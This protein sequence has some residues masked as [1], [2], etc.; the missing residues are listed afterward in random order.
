MRHRTTKNQTLTW[1]WTALAVLIGTVGCSEAQIEEGAEGDGSAEPAGE[2]VVNVY[3]HRHYPADVELMERFTEETGIEV[4][5]VT[6]SA[7]ELITRLENEGE[8]S[9]ADVLITVD[10][11][12][13]HRAKTRDLLQPVDSEVLRENVPE[14]LRDRDGTW[15][16]LTRRARVIVYHRERVDSS[17]LS[18]Y[19][20]LAEPAWDDRVL[21]RSSSNVYNQSLLASL[22]AH[23]GAVAGVAWGAGIVLNMARPPRGGDTDQIKAVVAGAGDV[24]V[25]NTYYVARLATSEDPAEREIAEQ[26][27][28]FFPNQ[29]G[30]GAHVNVSGAGVTRSADHVEEATLLLEFL[31]SDEAQRVFAEANQEY[32]VKPGVAW[33]ETLRE[34]GEFEADTLDLTRLGELNDEAVRIFDRVG[35]R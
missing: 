34:W 17:G 26:V 18:T 31:T 29:D 20:A 4:N 5:M 6:A 28:V 35:W 12:R 25:V 13:L 24:A 1:L 3:S 27:G 14:H 30:R 9:P 16:G 21:I 19:E 23:L 2:R 7:D 22:I 15:F 32:P 8:A 10:A 11:G 33:S